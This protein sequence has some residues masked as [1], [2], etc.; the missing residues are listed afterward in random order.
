[1]P[2]ETILPA[3]VVVV[4]GYTVFG[5]TGF[6]ASIVALP[7]LAHLMPLRTAVPMMLIFDLTAG[8]TVGLRNRRVV[9][10]RELLHIVPYMLAGMAVGAT[11]LVNAPER[12]L[13]GVLGAFVLAY[14][15][16][17]LFAPAARAQI[18]AGWA[19]PLG[20]AGG[21]FTALFGTGGPLYTVYLARRIPDTTALRAT[22]SALIVLS[23]IARLAIFTGVGLY[24]HGDA[25]RLALWLLPCALLGVYVGSR[26]HARL[27]PRRIVQAI[28]VVLVVGGTSL[29]WRSVRGA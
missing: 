3:A 9:A 19:A 6:G 5:L 2:I 12:I 15:A 7:L 8:L 11:A 20:V 18:A 10:R 23:G 1:M 17:G 26:T 21:V 29:L 16:F 28:W 4:A 13:L 14:A 24:A 22:L 25:L 27:A